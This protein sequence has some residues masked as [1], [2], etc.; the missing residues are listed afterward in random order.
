MMHFSEKMCREWL[1][2]LIQNAKMRV[3]DREKTC[4]G[5]AWGQ[6]CEKWQKNSSEHM[7]I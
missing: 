7:S 2:S 1:S 4:R 6:G 3:E 5:L